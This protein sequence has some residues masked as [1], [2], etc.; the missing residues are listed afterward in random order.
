MY[1][2]LFEQYQVHNRY[3]LFEQYQ[4][5]SRYCRMNMMGLV[6]LLRFSRGFVKAEIELMVTI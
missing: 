4:V 2:E 3:C 5:H 6:L 1:P